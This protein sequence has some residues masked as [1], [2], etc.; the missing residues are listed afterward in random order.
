MSRHCATYPTT[1]THSRPPTYPQVR[2]RPAWTGRLLSRPGTSTPPSPQAA[3]DEHEAFIAFL[4]GEL[5]IAHTQSTAAVRAVGV[6]DGADGGDDD[7][8]D[9]AMEEVE[10]LLRSLGSPTASPCHWTDA[11]APPSQ[12]PEAAL[13][14][15]PAAATT[16][17]EASPPPPGTG[18]GAGLETPG[19]SPRSATRDFA[20]MRSD[21]RRFRLARDGARVSLSKV[22]WPAWTRFVEG[23]PGHLINLL[24]CLSFCLRHSLPP[25]PP[26]WWQK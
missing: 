10:D 14:A 13:G 17:S 21:M 4:Q 25:S 6:F 18:A 22:R 5:E 1:S 26:R 15:G 3:I 9:E 11:D 2:L 12:S 20:R 24:F 7:S 8:G 16:N 19:T 23:D